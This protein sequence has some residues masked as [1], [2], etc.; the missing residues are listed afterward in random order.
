MRFIKCRLSEENQLRT[1]GN[2]K[3]RKRRVVTKN[4][5]LWISQESLKVYLVNEYTKLIS[6]D[7]ITIGAEVMEIRKILFYTLN[8]L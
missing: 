8:R 1:I 2:E 7:I 6:P 5:S 3:Y 4:N